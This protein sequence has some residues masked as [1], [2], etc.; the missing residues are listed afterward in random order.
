MRHFDR[1]VS[2]FALLRAE[3]PQLVGR[4]GASDGHMERLIGELLARR[5]A[6]GL[7]VVR[8]AAAALEDVDA[9]WIKSG[10]GM[11]VERRFDDAPESSVADIDPR[12]A[13]PQ[14]CRCRFAGK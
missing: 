4:I 5:E 13:R 10:T 8:G 6:P 11:T 7:T 12:R 3:R 9:A 1:L 14:R 2:A